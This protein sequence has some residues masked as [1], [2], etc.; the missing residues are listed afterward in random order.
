MGNWDCRAQPSPSQ[1]CTLH[2]ISNLLHGYPAKGDHHDS[3][4]WDS[5]APPSPQLRVRRCTQ[6][7]EEESVGSGHRK[8]QFLEVSN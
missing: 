4:V 8:T 5:R 1:V 7:N 3:A 6:T 2:A